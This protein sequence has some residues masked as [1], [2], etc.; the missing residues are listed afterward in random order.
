MTRMPSDFFVDRL[1]ASGV[2][3]IHGYSGD[4]SEGLPAHMTAGL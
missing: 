3:R 2:K 1:K 4:G